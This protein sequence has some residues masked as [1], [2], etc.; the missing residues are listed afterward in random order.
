M[1]DHRK[2]QSLSIN[3]RKEEMRD[4]ELTISNFA[5][6]LIYIVKSSDSGQFSTVFVLFSL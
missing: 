2:V 5:H 6:P 3:G 1:S 4:E